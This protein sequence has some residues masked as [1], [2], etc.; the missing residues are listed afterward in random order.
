MEI[1][2]TEHLEKKGI[3]MIIYADAGL[4]KTHLLGTLPV[5]EILIIDIEGG[6]YTL[7]RTGHHYVSVSSEDDLDLI[8]EIYQALRTNEKHYDYVAIDSLSELERFMQF[9][10]MRARNKDFLTLKE[11]G[12]SSQKMREFIRLF[13]DL[14]EQGINVIFT[15]LEMSLDI[16][17][18]V[19]GIIT[20]SFPLVS[21]K[22]APEI[23]G[24]VDIVGHLEMSKDGKQRWLRLEA[25]DRT[26]AK[27]RIQ[28]LDRFEPADLPSLFEKIKKGD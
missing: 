27:T 10:F 15:A 28:G 18:N 23:V 7:N 24:L 9:S 5:G 25:T 20:K 26:I 2:N 19:D 8:K 13:R 4:G 6:I 1:Q 11:Y 12:D 16:Q 21:R 22:L 3:S 14:T 17:N